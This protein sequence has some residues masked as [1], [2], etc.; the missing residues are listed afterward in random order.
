MGAVEIKDHAETG[1]KD[2]CLMIRAELA[3]QVGH[4]QTLSSFQ[5][6]SS[7]WRSP[8]MKDADDDNSV[9]IDDRIRRRICGRSP[10]AAACER[11]SETGQ[12]W[13]LRV[14]SA[15]ARNLCR[16]LPAFVVPVSGFVQIIARSR[17]HDRVRHSLRRYGSTS[18]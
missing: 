10:V 4:V 11:R 12:R 14:S 6:V 17:S 5:R 15:L 7:P 18:S 8:T 2:G 16:A 1:H 9:G 3:R 13:L